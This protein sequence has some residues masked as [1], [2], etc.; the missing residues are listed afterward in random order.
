MP[1]AGDGA[2]AEREGDDVRWEKRQVLKAGGTSLEGHLRTRARP[3]D[4]GRYWVF[5]TA[6]QKSRRRSPKMLAEH[7]NE[8]V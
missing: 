3:P 2:E 6:Q 8:C 4:E 1:L 7:G 5:K